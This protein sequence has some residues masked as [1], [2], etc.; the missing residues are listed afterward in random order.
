MPIAITLMLES[1]TEAVLP[2]DLGRANYAAA[3]RAIA[4]ID[5][6]LAAQIH[7]GDGP[8]PITCSLLWGARRTRE[9]MPVR[10]G[11][12]YFVRI[13]GLTP[14]VEE[15]L[16]LA[17]LHNPPKTWELDRHMFRVVRTTDTPEEDPT[18][19]A[20]RQS[21]AEMVQTY[22]QGRSALRKRITLEFASP[23]AFR[24][25]EKQIT[26]PLPGLVFGSLVERWNA[27]APIALSAD[28]RRFAEECIAVSRYRLQSRPVDQKN[29]A[30]RIGAIGEATY[31]ALR[32]DVYWVSV[33]NLLA[34]F[35]RFGGVGVQT[36]TGMGQVRTR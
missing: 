19:W 16:D 31:I 33:F 1:E 13:T 11:E 22:L 30:L 32:Y 23:T 12:T 36:T 34:D 10:P 9:G 35:A 17:L 3:L 20:G 28:M 14:E 25:Q 2:R 6:N 15:A 7:D 29:K 21:Y 27:F 18:G 26:L 24:S 5:E 8:K 4:R